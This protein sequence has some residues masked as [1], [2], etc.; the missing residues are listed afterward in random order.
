MLE[1]TELRMYSE[2][3]YIGRKMLTIGKARHVFGGT[4]GPEIIGKY[5]S[6]KSENSFPRGY[7]NVFL[8][9]MELINHMKI[10]T[11][12]EMKKI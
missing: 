7:I 4:P 11:K 8:V 12:L 1:T 10:L 2:E 3:K 5:Q 9:I 6:L